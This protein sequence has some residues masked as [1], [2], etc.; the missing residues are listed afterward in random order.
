MVPYLYALQYAA[1]TRDLFRWSR[2]ELLATQWQKVQQLVGYAYSHVPFYHQLWTEHGISPADIQ[3]PDDLSRIPVVTKADLR[4][5]YPK[6]TLSDELTAGQ[7]KEWSTSGSTGEP[8]KFAMDAAAVGY[9]MAVNLRTCTLSGY[10]LGKKVLQVA[11]PISGGSN[12]VM[13]AVDAVLRRRVVDAFSAEYDEAFAFLDSFKPEFIVGYTSYIY[14]LAKLT[15]KRSWRPSHDIRGVMTTSETLLPQMRRVISEAFHT[16]VFDQYGSNEFGRVAGECELH[17]GYH[18][19]M[20]AA[21]I[22]VL[23]LDSD[24]V[25]GAGTPGRLVITGLL[26][27]AMPLIRYDIGD[28]GALSMRYC[29]CGWET[30]L[31]TDIGGRLQDVLWRADGTPVPPDYLYRILREYDEIQNYQ[32]I[33][34]SHAHVRIRVVERSPLS[35]ERVR[36]IQSRVKGYLGSSV[37]VERVAEIPR[38]AGKFRHIISMI[39]N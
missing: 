25:V 5:A 30:L 21:Y 7:W 20:D 11:P 24:Q 9:Q 23:D 31:L 22:E 36:D 10:A 37:Q 35:S 6:D 38:V 12:L 27:R 2:K 34:E 17:D 39:N 8:F 16:E 28:I 18:L 1:R 19:N 3:G 29:P 32:V 15:L 26:N 4:A 13:Q 33:Q 14:I